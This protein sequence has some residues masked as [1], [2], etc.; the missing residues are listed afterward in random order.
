MKEWTISAV[1]E[2][3]QQGKLTCL[4]LVQYY[5][6]RIKNMTESC[7]ALFWLIPMR[8]KKPQSLTKNSNTAALPA[9]CMAYLLF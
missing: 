9:R 1:H 5:L 8:K 4:E 2:A 7:T 3:M 6:E